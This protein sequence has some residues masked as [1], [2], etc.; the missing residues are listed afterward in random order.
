MTEAGASSWAKQV[1][2]AGW[3]ILSSWEQGLLSSHRG[4]RRFYLPLVG[5]RVFDRLFY[6][7]SRMF[8]LPIVEAILP[9]VGAECIIILGAGTGV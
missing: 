2:G 9:T 8:Y 4:S 1:V 7:G 6:S 3:Y 5:A